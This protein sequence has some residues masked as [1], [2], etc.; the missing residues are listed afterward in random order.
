MDWVDVIQ[1]WG[2]AGAAV[3]GMGY[4]TH[5]FLVFLGNH[6]SRNTDALNHVA[7]LLVGVME[8]TRDCPRKGG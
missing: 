3:C 7:E 1:G 2:P 8:T 6:L 4:I 5:R